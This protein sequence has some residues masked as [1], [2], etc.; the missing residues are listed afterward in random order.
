M[1]KSVGDYL[2]EKFST[3][4]GFD[5]LVES[6]DQAP[7]SGI[8]LI[9]DSTSNNHN[10]EGYELSVSEDLIKISSPTEA[11][12]FYGIQTLRQ[13]LPPEIEMPGLQN[14]EWK[15]PTGTIVDY[16][17]YAWRGTMLDV[18]RHF[19]SVEDVKRYIDLA[20]YYKINIMH[21]HLSDDQGWRIEIKSW[22]NLTTHGGSTAVGGGKGGFFTQEQYINIIEYAKTRF[23]TIIP[24][25]DLPGHINAALASYGELN[26]GTIVPEEG[27]VTPVVAPDLGSKSRPTKLYT[28]IA[29]GWS[30]LRVEKEVSFR[31]TEDVIREISAITPG[32]YFHIGGDEAAATKKEDYITFINRFKGIVKNNNKIMIGWDEIA[33]AAID[34]SII[35][36]H[37]S[38]AKHA[39]MAVEK[40]SK[41]IMSP[42]KKAY[43]D[44]SYDSTSKL[45]L[46]WAA[47][48]EVDSA[49]KWNLSTHI[50]S[51]DRFS[52]LGIEAPLW[53]ET[54]SNMDELEYLAFPRLPGY[55]EIGWSPETGRG[56]DEYKVRLG[57]HGQYMRAMGID[58]YRS[59]L[60]PWRD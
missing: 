44:M 49:Y 38:S 25:I 1:L 39:E 4:T 30:T 13:L 43:L 20:S 19:F 6:G 46:H 47:Y 11:G 52:I 21:L 3:A 31:F 58:F 22:P 42:A 45:G 29:V 40:G 54:I 60:V 56:W 5:L 15:I 41:L 34:S 32:P 14:T 26:G 16:P 57:N 23:I 37:W 53:S 33:Q 17:A 59:K 18:A 8:Y 7:A 55:A 12:I 51:I 28:G 35:T 36:Q 27:K 2:S 48:I 9:V 24:E 50:K 10:P